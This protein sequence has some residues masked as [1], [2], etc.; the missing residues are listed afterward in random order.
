MG[1]LEEWDIGNLMKFNEDKCSPP[2]RSDQ[3]LGT[4]LKASF[5]GCL[6][7]KCWSMLVAVVEEDQDFT[8]AAISLEKRRLR[9][10]LT[11]VYSVSKGWGQAL[12]G[13]AEQ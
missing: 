1:R 8:P 3:P 7:W 6:C 2:S 11:N 13:G 4:I 9:K 12:F 10:D 5:T